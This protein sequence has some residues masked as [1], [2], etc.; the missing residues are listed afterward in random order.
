MKRFSTTLDIMETQ[1]KTTTRYHNPPIRT[2]KIIIIT[3]TSCS[4]EAAEKLDHSYIAG[5]V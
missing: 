5:A 4:D 1:I 2:T 3:T